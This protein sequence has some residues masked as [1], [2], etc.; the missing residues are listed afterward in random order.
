MQQCSR[1]SGCAA[2][3]CTA[4]YDARQTR[5][6]F[7]VFTMRV[8]KHFCLSHLFVIVFGINGLT[9][10]HP[11]LSV[12]VY[13]SH[14]VSTACA[15]G[16]AYALETH[17]LRLHVYVVRVTFTEQRHDRDAHGCGIAS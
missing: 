10:L 5:L 17:T 4:A 2:I 13:L 15:F 3:G 7:D 6:A 16:G 11:S 1:V 14:A 9:G 8:T 12:Q